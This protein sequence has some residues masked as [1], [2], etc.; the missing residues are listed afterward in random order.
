MQWYG[1]DKGAWQIWC[2]IPAKLFF[3]LFIVEIISL[4]ITDPPGISVDVVVSQI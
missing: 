2:I 4:S 1:L 3:T